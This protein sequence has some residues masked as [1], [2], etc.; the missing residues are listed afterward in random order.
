MFG[1]MASLREDK[2]RISL[3]LRWLTIGRIFVLGVYYVYYVKQMRISVD[4]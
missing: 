3:L 2:T 1:V 4:L